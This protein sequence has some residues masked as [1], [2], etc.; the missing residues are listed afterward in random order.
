[1]LT[2]QSFF[3]ADTSFIG[4]P[5]NHNIP[6]PSIPINHGFGE[7]NFHHQQIHNQ[8]HDS[9]IHHTFEPQRDTNRG[10]GNKGSRVNHPS[11]H[12]NIMAFR[13]I[14]DKIVPL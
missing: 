2:L 7:G 3:Q 8:P 4:E 14:H 12:Y 6:S 10:A 13:T 9:D 11:K 5:I 1:M